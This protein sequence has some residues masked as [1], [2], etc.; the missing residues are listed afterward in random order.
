MKRERGGNSAY[1][2]KNK[3]QSLCERQPDMERR[4]ELKQAGI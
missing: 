2:R 1:L 4:K 3:R